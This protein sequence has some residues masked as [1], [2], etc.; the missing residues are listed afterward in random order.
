MADKNLN[1]VQEIKHN[2]SIKLKKMTETYEPS[3]KDVEF[4]G[5]EKGRGKTGV[6]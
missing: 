4:L 1:Y 3:S 5:I 2:K 6:E